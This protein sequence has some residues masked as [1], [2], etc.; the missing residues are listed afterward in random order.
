MVIEAGLQSDH[1]IDTTMAK[2]IAAEHW[3]LTR[4]LT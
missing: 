3:S 2:H 1:M 4:E